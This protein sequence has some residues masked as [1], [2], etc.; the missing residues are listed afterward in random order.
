MVGYLDLRASLL[1]YPLSEVLRTRLPVDLTLLCDLT[2]RLSGL[3]IMARSVNSLGGV[4]HNVTMPRSWFIALILPDTDL[5]QDT[6][7]FFV[8]AETMVDLMQQI[9]AQIQRST[10]SA[11]DAEEQF[12][13]DGSMM[14]KFMGSLCIARM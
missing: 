6:S 13:V 7:T 9:D 12:T 2:E 4:L 10:T 14:S 5:R 3:F 11:S 8:F 1:I